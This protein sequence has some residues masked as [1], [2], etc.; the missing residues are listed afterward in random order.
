MALRGVDQRLHDVVGLGLKEKHLD[1]DLGL[2]ERGG[3]SWLRCHALGGNQARRTPVWERGT[4]FIMVV[5]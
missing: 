4:H 1:Q 3:S 2:V 5:S